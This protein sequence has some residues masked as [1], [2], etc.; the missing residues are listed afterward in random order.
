[1]LN[2]KRA[3][4]RFLYYRRNLSLSL[5]VLMFAVAAAGGA[6][7]QPELKLS[8]GAGGYFASDFGGGWQYA[9]S[10]GTDI[11][12][13]TPY[14]GGGGWL[15]FDAAFAEASL[16]FFAA[17]GYMSYFENNS[18]EQISDMPYA[19]LDIGLMGKYPF[20]L[21]ERFTLFPLLGIAYRSFISVKI[22]GKD[23]V[24]KDWSALWFKL[25]GG[26]DY[27]FTDHVY[28]RLNVVY[29]IRLA[30]NLEK[31]WVHYA[32]ATFGNGETRLGHG[33]DVKLAAGYTF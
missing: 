15:F 27:A 12:Y 1:M 25:G 10:G 20:A 7:A 17:G 29:G 21:G 3:V 28:A 6:F 22:D 16:G 13:K 31:E 26:A 30:N 18:M 8:A 24:A 4:P 11:T 32:Q 19:G 2:L 14:A 23:D 5:L 33:L 9:G